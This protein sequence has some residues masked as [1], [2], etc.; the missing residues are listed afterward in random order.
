MTQKVVILGGGVAGLS[1]AHELLDRGF[2]VEVI[3]KLRLPGGK[4]RSIPVLAVLGDHGGKDAHVEAVRAA[5]AADPL[6]KR[7]WLPGE[8]GFRFFPNFYRH[9]TDTLARIPMDRAPSRTT[10]STPPRC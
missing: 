4:A 2:A 3:E 10:L 6:G 7:P 9:I 1:A 5:V 8:H